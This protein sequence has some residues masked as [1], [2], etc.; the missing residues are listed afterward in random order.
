M[1]RLVEAVTPHPHRGPLIAAGAVPFALAI[2]VGDVRMSG[3]WA[4]GVH[5]AVTV[6]AAIWI[7]AM[8]L[9]TPLEMRDPRGFHSVLLVTG[10]ALVALALARMARL[11]GADSVLQRA[12][13]L[14]W[15]LA[16]LSVAA[17][18]GAVRAHSAIGALIA[19]IAAGGALLAVCDWIFALRGLTTYRW[20]LLA[21]AVIYALWSLALREHHRRHAVQLV[22]AGGLAAIAIG[23]TLNPLLAYVAPGLAP[24]GFHQPWGWQ[25]VMLAAG[26]GLVAYAGSDH[27]AGPGYLGALALASFAAAS[28]FSGSLL[29]WPIVLLV[30]AALGLGF[31]LRPRR[32]LPPPPDADRPG[33][34]TR[35]LPLSERSEPD[36]SV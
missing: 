28:T 7:Y 3:H 17:I 13:T 2:Y 33:A 6:L 15:V 11:L 26:C 20:L 21:L 27:Q 8:A 25:L 18:A 12:G 1:R 19:A 36:G 32:P 31:G 35:A 4:L 14:A 34:E 5:A 23:L 22:N 29:G 10:L 16:L 24:G 9:L 30:L